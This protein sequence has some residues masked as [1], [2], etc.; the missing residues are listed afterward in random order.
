M[1]LSHPRVI[2]RRERRGESG[3][4]LSWQRELHP[5]SALGNHLF[6]AGSMRGL[7]RCV[8]LYYSYE[9]HLLVLLGTRAWLCTV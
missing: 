8:A 1:T 2:G 9:S 4:V 5:V 7:E 6:A 3:K